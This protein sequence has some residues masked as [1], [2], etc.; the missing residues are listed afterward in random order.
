MPDYPGDDENKGADVNTAWLLLSHA[1]WIA[2]AFA[3]TVILFAAF[4]FGGTFVKVV[5]GLWFIL[6]L[7][8]QLWIVPAIVSTWNTNRRSRSPVFGDKMFVSL[9][10][11]VLLT[12]ILEIVT[13]IAIV[14][15]PSPNIS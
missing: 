12:I 4:A 2:I 10:I 6:G 11:L 3:A 15:T 13:G 14:I 7:A 1:S 9:L 8:Y 5:G